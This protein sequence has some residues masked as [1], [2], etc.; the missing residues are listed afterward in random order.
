MPV[1]RRWGPM[2]QAIPDGAGILSIP[3]ALDKGP[4]KDLGDASDGTFDSVGNVQWSVP[5][6][7]RVIKQYDDFTLNDTHTLSLDDA[8]KVVLV[9]C[10][11]TFKVK[12]GATI[13]FRGKGLV[14]EAMYEPPIVIPLNV[15]PLLAQLFPDAS[16]DLETGDLL[17]LTHDKL[18]RG[19]RGGTAGFATGTPGDVDEANKYGLS[20]FAAGRPGGGCGAGASA[21]G[22]SWSVGGTNGGRP[23]A[24]CESIGSA[25][26]GTSRTSSGTSSGS[27]GGI[28]CGGGGSVANGSSSGTKTSGSGGA[29]PGGGGGGGCGSQESGNFTAGNGLAGTTLP[30]L[31][32]IVIAKHIVIESGGQILLDATG[33][34][35]DGGT[36]VRGASNDYAGGGGAGGGCGGGSFWGA[37]TDSYTND[38]TI[39]TSGSAPG[40]GGSSQSGHTGSSGQSGTAGAIVI[41]QV[42]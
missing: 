38:G 35:G 15:D 21:G 9:K 20:F 32:F 40:S 17:I 36:G 23:P 6:D 18:G 42:A 14:P 4:Q 24:P 22:G 34:G 13:D 30:G 41:R 25:G 3:P 39:S 5:V 1:N 11:G 12:A 37:Y 28:S 8:A 27:H 33:I 10:T 2:V 31:L 7:G 19:G 26:S 16:Y 29:G